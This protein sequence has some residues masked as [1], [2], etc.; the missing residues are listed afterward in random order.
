[1]R[2]KNYINYC[3]ILLVIFFPLQANAQTYKISGK[4]VDQNDGKG[5]FGVLI[6]NNKSH[7]I[8]NEDGAF[9][10]VAESESEPLY[11]SHIQ[12]QSQEQQSTANMI[13]RM[14]LSDT[15]LNEILIFK[16]PLSDVFALAF[17][18]ALKTMDKGDLYKTY[19]RQFNR[20][21]NEKTNLADGIVDFYVNHPNKRPYTAVLE[22]RVFTSTEEID[23]DADTDE[24]LNAFGMDIRDVL[25]IKKNIT[26]L[27]DIL[28]DNK[29]YD[30]TVQQKTETGNKSK[31]IVTFEPKDGLTDWLVFQGYIVFDESQTKVLEYKY[32]LADKYIDKIKILKLLFFKIQIQQ[33]NNY[34]VFI[35]DEHYHLFYR[36]HL[37]DFAITSKLIK[38][39]QVKTIQEVM[40]DQVYKNVEIP[41][42]KPYKGDLY[43]QKSNYSTEFWKDRNIRPLNK[44]EQEILDKLEKKS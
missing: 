30:Y 33:I 1:M 35:D 24:I 32:E 13:V 38:N 6:T 20:V 4:V 12:Y 34:V 44:W 5:I 17:R 37:M 8:T 21:N 7:T 43:K 22:H 11:F 15:Q 9:T 40:V 42:E 36:S 16:K 26:E 23:R 25:I 10:M 41:K 27:L 39:H 31:I 18:N 2:I 19:I 3:Y 28:K 14:P 29:N